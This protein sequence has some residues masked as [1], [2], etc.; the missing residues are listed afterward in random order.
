LDETVSRRV[1]HLIDAGKDFPGSGRAIEG[2][3]EMG[4]HEFR[5]RAQGLGFA[6]VSE[7]SPIF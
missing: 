5:P 4:D 2:T 1:H 7:M 3:R 6:S